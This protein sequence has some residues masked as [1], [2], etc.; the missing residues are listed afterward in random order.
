MKVLIE[1]EFLKIV[2]IDD[3]W[4]RVDKILKS[5]MI[6]KSYFDK[7]GKLIKKQ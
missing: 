4:I 2:E 1:N 5:V 6:V 3:L 7:S